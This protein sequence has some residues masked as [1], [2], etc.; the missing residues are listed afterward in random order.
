MATKIEV[1]KFFSSMGFEIDT[2]PL[3]KFERLTRTIRTS[4]V[5]LA[6]DLRQTNNQL[7]ST[8]SKLK[9]V[10]N[11]LNSVN[12]RKGAGNLAQSYAN[13]SRNVNV[14]QTALNR[15]ST[16]IT[17]VEPKLERQNATVSR[18]ARAWGNYAI[19]V[20]AAND[21]LRNRPSGS[22]PRPPRGGGAGSG[23]GGSGSGSGNPNPRRSGVAP[24]VGGIA[25]QMAGHFVN[26]AFM[27][28]AGGAFA[29]KEVIRVGREY[30]KMKQVLLASSKSQEEFNHHLKYAEDTTNRLGTNVTEF[31]SAYAKMLQAVGG[32]L[33]F[34]ET[35]ALF[36][37][38]SELMVVLGSSDD[39]QKG[40][41]R[42]MSQMFSK[43][44]IQMEEV[45]Q[46]AERNVPAL[47]M[48]TRAYKEL[49]MTQEEFEKAQR[50]GK[51]DPTKFLPLFGKYAQEFARNNG[52]LEKAMNSSV[53][54]QGIFMNK[55]RKL[56]NQI[57]ESGLDK[58]LGEM[59]KLLTKLGEALAPVA[60][61]ATQAALGFAELIKMIV[62]FAK[63]SPVAAALIGS[64]IAGFVGLR[65]AMATGMT[66]GGAFFV[67][68]IRGL[69]LL[70]LAMMRT[71]IL[72]V[73]LGIAEVFTALYEHMN[74]D[75]NWLSVTIKWFQLMG[76]EVELVY[77]KFLTLM[78]ALKVGVRDSWFGQLIDK[79]SNFDVGDAFGSGK[80]SFFDT[81]G[82]GKGNPVVSGSPT[83]PVQQKQVMQNNMQS[84]VNTI[85][86]GS[87]G[88]PRLMGKMAVDYNLKIV[89]GQQIYSSKGSQTVNV[90]GLR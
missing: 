16:T 77:Q 34:K 32:K 30:Q 68:M 52:A 82:S 48:L 42:A 24:L 43:G 2:A 51:L 78:T 72:A 31:G 12:S 14:A 60:I 59:F 23:S 62:S 53:T 46:M 86:R 88:D 27:A 11:G 87:G 28:G 41:F 67:A 44:K 10:T 71:A 49:G 79:M 4:T 69:T 38:F 35:E 21:E 3:E 26:P 66:V 83:V 40:I 5:K 81:F 84:Y 13:L 54:Q 58:A 76:S 9:S 36:T 25:G 57:M 56:S 63:E 61:F 37:R 45:N 17:T 8:A 55:M 65:V 7:S 18:L 19:R 39:D 75:K 22:P 1:A 47:A 80:K 50:E 29:V 20:R 73:I 90:G 85:P 89:N 33:S 74:G 64:L 15:I 6:R 70:K